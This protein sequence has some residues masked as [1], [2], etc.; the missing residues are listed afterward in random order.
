MVVTFR[1]AGQE[2]MALNGGPLFP[3]TEAVSL[4]VNCKTQKEV[5]DLWRKLSRGGKPQ[6]CG[7]IKDKYGMP[8][9]IVPTI[10][11]DLMRSKNAKKTNS[12]MA[13]L[14]KMVKLDSRKLKQAYDRG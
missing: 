4:V 9:Q 3:F 5:D 8:W 10:L 11:G 13:A 14:L 2:F 1:L 7:W 12:V 6:Q